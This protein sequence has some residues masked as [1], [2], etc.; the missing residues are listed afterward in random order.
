M[1][2]TPNERPAESPAWEEVLPTDVPA[3]RVATTSYSSEASD[4]PVRAGGVTAPNTDSTAD[5]AKGEAAAVK[6]TAVD[7]GR[8]VAE[9]TKDEA[10][11][12]ASEA[13]AQATSL[14]DSVGSQVQDQAGTQQR[15]LAE[16]VHGLA[17]ELGSMASGSQESGP[18]TDLA[19]QGADKGSEIA[20]WLQDKEPRDVLSEVESFARRRPALFLVLCGAAG[21]L[22]GRLTRGAIGANTSLD[23]PGDG[24]SGTGSAGRRE[25]PVDSVA[26]LI[27]EPALG[28][29]PSMVHQTTQGHPSQNDALQTYATEESG[30]GEYAAGPVGGGAPASDV[31]PSTRLGQR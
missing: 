5:V 13:K 15:R 12:V 31:D 26:P 23:T 3:T 6:D 14:L 24:D 11:N 29:N 22:A 9:T 4:V 18:L 10:A 28:E 2:S 21:V 8:S 19:R 17:G 20:R 7:A 25:L 30:S 16:T 1:T 27:D